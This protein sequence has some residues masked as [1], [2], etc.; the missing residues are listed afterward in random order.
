MSIEP[1]Y[2]NM[3]IDTCWNCEGDSDPI[4]DLY[5]CGTC[6]GKGWIYEQMTDSPH[7]SH[8]DIELWDKAERKKYGLPPWESTTKSIKKDGE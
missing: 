4:D 7:H 1:N 5:Y 8:F 2:P 3:E 6:Q